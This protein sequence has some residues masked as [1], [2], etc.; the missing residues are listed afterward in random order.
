MVRRTRPPD[1]RAGKLKPRGGDEL[2]TVVRLSEEQYST[3]KSIGTNTGLCNEQLQTIAKLLESRFTSIDKRIKELEDT[4]IK[5]GAVHL[6]GEADG[7]PFDFRGLIARGVLESSAKSATATASDGSTMHDSERQPL[8]SVQRSKQQSPFPYLTHLK[9][10]KK[11]HACI[12][13]AKCLAA[14]PK[15]RRGRQTPKIC[16]LS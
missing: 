3:L 16:P 7:A 6:D 15:E 1:T 11:D 9:N 8:V 12:C 5:E 4:A 2:S 13:S 14:R 10:C